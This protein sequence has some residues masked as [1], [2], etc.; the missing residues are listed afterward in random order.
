M[1]LYYRCE[2][3]AVLVPKQFSE[4]AVDFLDLVFFHT[5]N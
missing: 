1:Y 4:K 2:Y 5:K 3:A